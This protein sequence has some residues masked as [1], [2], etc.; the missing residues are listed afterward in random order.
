MPHR[1]T[2]AALPMCRDLLRRARTAPPTKG[3]LMRLPTRTAAATS[4]AAVLIAG[5]AACGSSK[6]DTAATPATDTAASATTE[7][8][9]MD[10]NAAVTGALKAQGTGNPFAD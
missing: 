2:A 8:A 5:L 1:A 9:G 3:F 10:M 6:S 4:L 7:H